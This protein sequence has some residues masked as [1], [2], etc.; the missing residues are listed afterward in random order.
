MAIN[1][2]VTDFDAWKTAYDGVRE[3]Q[4]AGGVRFQQVLRMPSEPNRV[5]VTHVF[6]T[7]EAAEAFAANPELK[8]A[9]GRAG[10]IE[11]SVKIM[12]FDEE[13]SGSV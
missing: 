9:M 4:H 7:R 12:F 3:M 2:E 11:S 1:H 5:Y 6:D 8:A 10:V 13:E